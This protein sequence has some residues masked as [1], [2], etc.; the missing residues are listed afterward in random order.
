M[1]ELL[2]GA[3]V[4]N[5]CP[6]CAVRDPPGPAAWLLPGASGRGAAGAAA[7]PG[8]GLGRAAGAAPARLPGAPEGQGESK[9]RRKGPQGLLRGR[10]PPPPRCF[11]LLSARC[12]SPGAA[13]PP[14]LRRGFA[15][16]VNRSCV[17][18]AEA[19]PGEPR[20]LLRLWHRVTR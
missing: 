18:G 16:G 2:R 20:C 1:A 3:D 12:C 7:C 8:R 5:L 4:G 14:V 17:V 6:L 13:V 9:P 10:P 15:W 19:V 11:R